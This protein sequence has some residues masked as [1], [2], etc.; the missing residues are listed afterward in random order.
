MEPAGVRKEWC[1]VPDSS[2]R[3]NGAKAELLI[4]QL[5]FLN[6]EGA[7]AELWVVSQIFVDTPDRTVSDSTRYLQK[8][9]A[10]FLDGRGAALLKY[11]WKDAQFKCNRWLSVQVW[12][13]MWYQKMKMKLIVLGIIVA[14]ILIII[15]SIFLGIC[16]NKAPGSADAF[17][18]IMA[19]KLHNG[20][21]KE[22]TVER[23]ATTDERLRYLEFVRQAAAQV[24]APVRTHAIRTTHENIDMTI[25]AADSILSQL[26]LAHRVR[27]R[28]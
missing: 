12:R 16:G 14:L 6:E 24:Q 2:L 18:M 15:L 27:S 8:V 21:P 10:I 23:A 4:P 9:T 26:D 22:V 17:L 19:K 13:K 5:E 1:V 20:L 7:H 25:K 28:C 11:Q 3:S